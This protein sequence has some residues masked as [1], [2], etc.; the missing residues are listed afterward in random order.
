M[1][2]A[3]AATGSYPWFI[4]RGEGMGRQALLLIH[5]IGEQRP[6][7]TLRGFAREVW[8]KDTSVHRPGPGAEAIWSK[9]YP[10]SEDF[11]LRRL[12]TGE[13]KSGQRT[14]FFEF[15]WAHLMKGTELK[16]VLAWLATLLLRLPGRVPPQL[17]PAYWVLWTLVLLSGGLAL[18]YCLLKSQGDGFWTFSVSVPAW[19][20]LAVSIVLLPVIAFLARQIVGDAARYLH[21]AAANVQMRHSIRSAGLRVLKDLHARGYDRI[22]VVGH[23]LGTVIAYDILSYAWSEWNAEKT[24][25]GG[26]D[27]A[28]D[29]MEALT[30][31]AAGGEDVAAEVFHDAQRACLRE[32]IANGHT[33]RVSDFVTLGSPL[34]HAP[35]L[36]A[37][38]Q[39]ALSAK[40]Q[41]R[42][43]AQCPPV[44][45]VRR[46]KG[47][48]V[49]SFRYF[50][51]K[52]S[53]KVLHHAALFAVTRWT[54]LYFP[55]RALLW[56]DLVGGPVAGVFGA[57]VRDV[58]VRTRRRFGLCSH[59]FYWR[60]ALRG[61][62]HIDK[63]RE[64]V[65]VLDQPRA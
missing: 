23:S 18:G 14:D 7:D 65:N 64:A 24:S 6:M 53:R 33:W 48:D 59:T 13:N 54:N 32:S 29:D 63:L 1:Q 21:V 52:L 57:G 61:D 15:Y 56:G 27:Q 34:A 42:E 60:A 8:S 20:S 5:G 40:F 41:E 25:P 22:V 12:T 55:C 31:R 39:K 36:L 11:E 4:N 16:H 43:Y 28:L 44:L 49:H 35:L 46:S 50:D 62:D 58:P 19:L 47:Q 51:K 2:D 30:V 9:P 38:D 37:R 10:L 3:D 17:R 26:V 45:E